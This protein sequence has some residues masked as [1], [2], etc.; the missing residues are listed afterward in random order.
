MG[1]FRA[2]IFC[3]CFDRHILTCMC[4]FICFILCVLL[5]CLLIDVYRTRLKSLKLFI[6]AN[7]TKPIYGFF[8]SCLTN[9]ISNIE[10]HSKLRRFQNLQ[11]VRILTIAVT[12]K[13]HIQVIVLFLGCHSCCNMLVSNER[14]K[15]LD[16][17]RVMEFSLMIPTLSASISSET[18]CATC[19]SS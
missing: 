7:S 19:Y 12:R 9:I 5:N 3:K 16:T 10:L 18:T 11:L 2:G 14:N 8:L 15:V 13:F 1:R 4:S 6:V 17:Y